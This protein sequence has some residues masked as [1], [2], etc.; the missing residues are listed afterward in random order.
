MRN[1]PAVE[2]GTW[3]TLVKTHRRARNM[4]QQALAD[5]AGCDRSTVWRWE[6]TDQKPD[7]AAQALRVAEVLGIDR[8]TAMRAT[9]FAPDDE[10]PAEPEL[11]TYAR[12]LGLDPHSVEV[13]T[14]LGGRWAEDMQRR[15]LRQEREWQEADRRRR[16]DQIKLAEELYA[17][18]AGETD[19]MD[20]TA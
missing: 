9:G 1:N 13:Q 16:L 7:S 6:N 20:K 12:S 14:I 10:R 17:T 4:S 18:T 19:G 2:S 11:W 3:A 5:A 15:M 8:D